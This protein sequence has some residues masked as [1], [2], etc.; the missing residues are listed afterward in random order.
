MSL[1]SHDAADSKALR[2]VDAAPFQLVRR[3]YSVAR[4]GL[5]AGL[6]GR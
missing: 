1:L 5:L 2:K 6:A 4:S 3:L